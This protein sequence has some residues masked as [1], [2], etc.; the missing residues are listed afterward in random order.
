M[1][2][3]TRSYLDSKTISSQAEIGY[4]TVRQWANDYDVPYIRK[5]GKIMFDEEVAELFEVIKELKNDGAGNDTIRRNIHQSVGVPQE[6]HRSDSDA[7]EM[8]QQSYENYENIDT[9]T[10]DSQQP[11]DSY[12]DAVVII[13]EKLKHSTTQAIEL[14]VKQSQKEFELIV[15]N[16]NEIAEK[17]SRAT[18]EVGQLHERVNHLNEKLSEKDKKIELLESQIKLLPPPQKIER[19][20]EQLKSKALENEDNLKEIERL[21]QALRDKENQLTKDSKKSWWSKIL[22]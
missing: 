2:E 11:Q 13:E 8:P 6:R 17:F 1:P 14:A 7:I 18:Y 19:L 15:Q 16:N 22:G 10:A 21:K 5:R 12:S 3:Q 9:P 4:S 20:E